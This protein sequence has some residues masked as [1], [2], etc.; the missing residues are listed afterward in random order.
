M[1]NELEIHNF[2]SI[3]DLTLPCKR[4]NLFIGEP[5]TGKSNI[6]EALGL[7]SFV[8]V[9]QYDPNARLDG[10]VRHER[11]SNLFYDENLETGSWIRWDGLSFFLEYYNG[12]YEGICSQ[13]TLGD[14]ELEPDRLAD[15]VGREG[16][17]GEVVTYSSAIERVN[18]SETLP[19]QIRFY[20]RPETQHFLPL[21][22]VHLLPPKGCNLVSIL[23]GNRELGKLVSSPF[24]SSGLKLLL[25]PHENRIDLAK[26]LEDM[27]VTAFPYSTVSETLQMSTFYTAAMETNRNAVIVLEEPEAHSFPGETKIL[28]E[29]IA[30][31]ENDNQY[32]I[33]THNPYFLMPLFSKAIKEDLA[34]NIVY[35]EDYRTNVRSLKDEEFSELFE[36]DIFANL[37]RFIEA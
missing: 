13:A 14:K 22:S 27:V 37:A 4:F 16:T 33:V 18:D 8:G 29:Q 36:L 3:K 15:F 32:F 35:V 34:I 11:L 12:I 25:R 1:I 31:D 5:N 20:R 17:T 7:V 9:R 2:K 24:N 19:S 23:A 28:A 21:N 26:N 10:F 6:L 30:M